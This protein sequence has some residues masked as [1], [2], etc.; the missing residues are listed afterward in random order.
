[1]L[2]KFLNILDSGYSVSFDMERI[3]GALK[4]SV[5]KN[6]SIACHYI[7][8]NHAEDFGLPKDIVIMATIEKLMRELE[9]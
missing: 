1:M 6:E 5:C 4:I 9:V 8:L 3:D 2:N 7:N